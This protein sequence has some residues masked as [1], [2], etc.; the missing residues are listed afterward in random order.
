MIQIPD[1]YEL[2]SKETLPD[3][4]SDGYL[5]R[6]KKS[7][8]RLVLLEN[9]DENKVFYIG[10]RTPPID[11]CGTAHITEH[12]VLCGSDKYPI[13]DPFVELAKGSMN[14]FLNAMTYPDKTVYPIASTND[15]DFA[16]LMD[17]YMDAVL[18][19]NIAKHPEI[20]KQE[21]WHYELESPDGELT[22]N[23]VVYNEMK[24]AFSSPDD[25]LSRAIL[26]SLF[27]DTA[28]QYESGGDPDDIPQLSY[29]KFLEFHA[30][31]YH[32]ANSY[33]YLYGDMDM[34][35]RL[36]WLDEAYLSHYDRIEVD[37]EIA[38]QKPFDKPIRITQDYPIA[39]TDDEKEATYLSY[40]MV[41]G[42]VLD[43]KLYAAFE[44]LDYALLSSPGAPIRKA[45]V[46]AG[47]GKD[48]LGGYDNGTLQPVFSV[49]AK[50]TDIDREAE[51]LKIIEDVCREQAD[52][53]LDRKTLLAAINSTEFKIREA[54]FGSYPKGL[55]YGLN[56]LD[57]WLYDGDAPFLHLDGLRV[58]QELKA[59][60]D[61]G[62]FEQL[63]RDYLLDNHHASVVIV[64]P[65]KGLTQERDES[66][67]KKLS[68]YKETLS[69][70]EK[71]EL[72]AETAHLKEYQA[73]PSTQE[74]LL[75]LPLLER[76]D[77]RQQVRPF[78]NRVDEL[79]ETPVVYAKL[80]THG[81]QY[82]SFLFE[83]KDG[84]AVLVP[85]LSLFTRLLG[86]VDTAN[87][88]YT[89]FS[90]EVNLHT[91][92]VS[93]IPKL[94]A[95]DDGTFR[96]FA[97]VHIKYLYEEEEKAFELLDEM[98]FASDFADEKRLK[99]LLLQEVSSMQ[100]KLMSAGHTL[101]AYRAGSYFAENLKRLDE[102][103]GIA[104]Y[105]YVKD[106]S[107]HFE[108]RIQPFQE[109]CKKLCQWLFTRERLTVSAICEQNGYEPLRKRLP[110]FFEKLF[111]GDMLTGKTAQPEHRNEGIGTA[112]QVQYVS[113]AGNFRRHGFGY[114]G[115]MKVLRVLLNY[116]YFWIN[117]RVK[118]G[119][120]GCM[121]TFS[122]N[123]N[124]MFSSYRDPNLAETYDIFKGTAD[125]LASFE[126]SDRD[127]RKYVIGTVSGMDTPLTPSQEGMRSLTAYLT[128][129]TEERLQKERDEVL[130]CT[131][132]DIRALSEVIRSV[133]DEGYVC[134]I[135]NEEAIQENEK[136]FD[137]VRS[138]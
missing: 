73:T 118:G 53:G 131:V 23:G 132:E 54:D 68:D 115:A 7:G 34:A 94:Y 110:A 97:E 128:G 74:E 113:A 19:P 122:R 82:L 127:M 50:G 123:G 67:R 59:D 125:Y 107:E 42:D 66:L 2:I 51:F 16:N 112:A 111:A 46:D 60:L 11:S 39:S 138:L 49:I 36:H 121:S 22:L 117:I 69:E 1:T 102:I 44:L 29:E 88:S 18:H 76:K 89:A 72:I 38:M 106:F 21:G 77:L 41:I 4:R 43:Q 109:E 63:I 27:P 80:D 126:A 120:Y 6:H 31:Y 9:D 40:N 84:E 61:S 13:K 91:G 83:I 108:E 24:G 78:C 65:K 62:Y 55:L 17:V 90:N 133:T 96:F 58:L 56:A 86:F 116:E 35:E 99:E 48:I 130:S 64:E 10:F 15:K 136:L 37:S 45:L 57:S 79:D 5:L 47:I 3:L 26:N 87:Y 100:M 8:A 71:E 137:E 92:G 14:T 114:S 85:E 98:L 30:M 135:G 52:G 32:P 28:Y 70:K 20:F 134:T 75:T 12:S 25:V 93:V 124:V 119:A 129:M 81:I 33:I 105:E 103:S 95:K 104:Y 101:S